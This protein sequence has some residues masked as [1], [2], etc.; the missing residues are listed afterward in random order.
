[1]RLRSHP[2]IKPVSIRSSMNCSEQLKMTVLETRLIGKPEVQAL[3]SISERTL[4]NL[5]RRRRFPPPLRLGKTVRWAEPVVQSW[6]QL[7]LA[8]QFEWKPPRGATSSGRR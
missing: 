3:L 6:L 1:T 2:R 7:Q 5:V 4:E 8:P